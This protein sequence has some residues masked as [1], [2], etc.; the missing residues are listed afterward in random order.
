MVVGRVG[1]GAEV[2]R[3][4]VAAVGMARSRVAVEA[5]VGEQETVVAGRA[6]AAEGWE[7]AVAV[8][9]EE[10]VGAGMVEAQKG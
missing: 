3:G 1:R 10:R 8:E 4:A 5:M 7:M 9:K 2:A 6:M